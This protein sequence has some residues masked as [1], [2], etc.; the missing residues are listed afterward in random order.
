MKAGFSIDSP[1]KTESTNYEN[2]M[3]FSQAADTAEKNLDEMFQKKLD[4]GGNLTLFKTPSPQPTPTGNRSL[5]LEKM[6]FSSVQ[7]Q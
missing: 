3:S 5:V 4:F 7:S 1:V 2:N 6:P